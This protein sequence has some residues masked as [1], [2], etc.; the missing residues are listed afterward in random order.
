MDGA[1]EA[2]EG[3]LLEFVMDEVADG[4]GEGEAGRSGCEAGPV[5]GDGHYMLPTCGYVFW[6]A[7]RRRRR[8]RFGIGGEIERINFISG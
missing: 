4:V 6:A 8:S 7:R 2:R 5:D 3:D 1:D